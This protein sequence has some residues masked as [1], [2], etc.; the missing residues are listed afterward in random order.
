VDEDLSKRE[1]QRYGNETK[2]LEIMVVTKIAGDTVGAVVIVVA[3]TMQVIEA[4]EVVTT[5]EMAI[6]T[7][8]T[9][10]EMTEM[11]IATETSEGINVHLIE[12]EIVAVILKEKDSSRQLITEDKENDIKMDIINISRMMTGIEIICLKDQKIMKE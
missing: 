9:L 12:K 10:I 2:T 1:T 8:E 5:I 3:E 4:A 7:I 11:I 6:E